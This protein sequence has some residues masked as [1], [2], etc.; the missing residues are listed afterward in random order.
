M[1]VP[2]IKK[3]TSVH[4]RLQAR[5]GGGRSINKSI[6]G[7]F[8]SY[9]DLILPGGTDSIRWGARSEKTSCKKKVSDLNLR[10]VILF[11]RNESCPATQVC[12]HLSTG[13]WVRQEQRFLGSYSTIDLCIRFSEIMLHVLLSLDFIMLLIVSTI[14]CTHVLSIPS[15]PITTMLHSKQC[16]SSM[17]PCTHAWPLHLWH[18]AVKSPQSPHVPLTSFCQFRALY[19]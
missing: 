11:G 16:F 2:R 18:H 1:A 8:L 6:D 7:I 12:I 13:G 10:R 17:W 19:W 14:K 5:V 4:Q 3:R 9:L 15:M